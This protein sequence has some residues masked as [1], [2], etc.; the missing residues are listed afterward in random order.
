MF[1]C[2]LLLLFYS[3]DVLFLPRKK[4]FQRIY[5]NEFSVNFLPKEDIL[6]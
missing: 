5:F 4:F 1:F 6:Y 2:F 3:I